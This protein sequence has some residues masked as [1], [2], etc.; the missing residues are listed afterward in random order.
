MAFGKL[1][2]GLLQQADLPLG[3]LEAFGHELFFKLQQTLVLG[4]HV[5]LEPNIAN[6]RGAND[7]SFK[8]QLV[9]NAL[10]AEGGMRK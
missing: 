4:F 8:C 7:K 3:Q 10:L 6:G 9:G 1:R 5:R 2:I